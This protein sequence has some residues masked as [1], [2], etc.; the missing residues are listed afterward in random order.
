MAGPDFPQ[1]KVQAIV[2]VDSAGWGWV[3]YEMQPWKQKAPNVRL[4]LWEE[5]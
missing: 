3:G 2:E 5:H 4:E 1:T